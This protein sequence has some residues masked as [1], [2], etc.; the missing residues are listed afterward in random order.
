MKD[1]QQKIIDN[2]RRLPQL[3]VVVIVV[4]WPFNV[5]VATAAAGTSSQFPVIVKGRKLIINN[6]TSGTLHTN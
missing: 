6:V 3:I 4:F 5:L 2:S 1:E